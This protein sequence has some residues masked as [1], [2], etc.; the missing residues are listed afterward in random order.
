MP[1]GPQELQDEWNSCENAVEF[2]R[3]AG[4]VH[5]SRFTWI[6]PREP[7]EQ[8]WRAIDYLIMEWDWGGIDKESTT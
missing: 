6:P 2:L 8:E 3:G 7:T 5:T 1:Q 4:F